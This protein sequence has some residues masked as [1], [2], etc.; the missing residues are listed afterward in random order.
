MAVE[1]EY[2][3]TFDA[4]MMIGQ[5]AASRSC[6]LP[7]VRDQLFSASSSVSGWKAGRRCELKSAVGFANDAVPKAGLKVKLALPYK[8]VLP[9][10]QDILE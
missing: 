4:T 9:A 5:A 6:S 8:S 7:H 2:W 3:P 10:E 1:V